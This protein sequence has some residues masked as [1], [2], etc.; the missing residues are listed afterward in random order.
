[1]SDERDVNQTKGLRKYGLDL[2]LERILLH[3]GERFVALHDP[4]SFLGVGQEST[5]VL[6]NSQQQYR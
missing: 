4:N 2:V 5:A 6:Q 3:K 1:M